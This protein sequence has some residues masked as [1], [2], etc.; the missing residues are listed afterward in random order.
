MKEKILDT[1]TDL[2][3]NYG[4]KSV[5]M[6]D[7]AHEMGISKKTIY[8]HYANKTKL[9]EATTMHTFDEISSGINRICELDK[10]PIE[11][12]YDIKKFVMNHLKNEKISSQYQLQKYYPKLFSTLNKKSFEVMIGCVKENLKRGIS[13]KLYRSTIDVD[14]IAILYFHNMISLKDQE[15][16]SIKQFSSSAL[17]DNYLEYHIR[18]ICT[19]IG[20]EKL[21]ILIDKK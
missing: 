3:L 20:L 5:T 19:S 4:F 17:M 1:A 16:F 14:F 8:Q 15:L 12:V 10:N 21:N 7:I 9:V 6:D 13:K 18:G 11:E 2:F